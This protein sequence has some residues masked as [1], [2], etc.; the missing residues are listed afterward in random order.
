MIE[1]VSI[2]KSEAI[3]SA[4]VEKGKN[5]AETGIKEI[6]EIVIKE[7]PVQSMTE[8]IENIPLESLKYQNELVLAEKIATKNEC[9]AGTVHPE[10]GVPFERST[11]EVEGTVKEGVFPN[12]KEWTVFETKLPEESY[13]KGDKA[14]ID[15]CNREL[16]VA[17]KNDP[18]IEG[19]FTEEQLEEIRNEDKP[20]GYTWHHD[21]SELGRMQLIDADVHSRTGHT[22]G[23]SIWG[24][25]YG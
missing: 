10:T 24:G 3:K 4:I 19:K 2:L 25:Q 13:A 14:H 16:M 21:G 22:G 18:K 5:I 6:P 8:I 9:L 1:P 15:F 11:I 12:F 23:M 17:V 7:S 20:S